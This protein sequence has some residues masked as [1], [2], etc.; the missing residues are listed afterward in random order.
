MARPDGILTLPEKF[1]RQWAGF[2]CAK[3]AE[4]RVRRPERVK[5]FHD[6]FAKQL[7]KHLEKLPAGRD[8]KL[9]LTEANRGDLYAFTLETAKHPRNASQFREHICKNWDVI[10]PPEEPCTITPERRAELE[11]EN[12]KPILTWQEHQDRLPP[13]PPPAPVQR[14]LL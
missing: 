6:G 3:V 14:S 1:G 4:L 10:P 9:K 2:Y 13:P 11:A 12:A 5:E 8:L 7:A